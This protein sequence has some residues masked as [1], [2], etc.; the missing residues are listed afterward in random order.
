MFYIELKIKPISL[1][2]F[3]A[4]NERKRLN[5]PVGTELDISDDINSKIKFCI[6][7][8]WATKH[9]EHFQHHHTI[10]LE[11]NLHELNADHIESQSQYVYWNKQLTIEQA[12]ELATK[13][14]EPTPTNPVYRRC[15]CTKCQMKKYYK[16]HS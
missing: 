14:L 11:F 7:E 15:N 8:D 13:I 5:L 4:Y 10:L 16:E 12:K 3:D 9:K 2:G 6:G 1:R